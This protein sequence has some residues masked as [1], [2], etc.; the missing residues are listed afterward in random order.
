[1]LIPAANE[2]LLTGFD[3]ESV[4]R[5]SEELLLGDLNYRSGNVDLYA[6]TSGRI[7]AWPFVLDKI[8]KSPF[9]GYG[10]EAMIRT[11]ISALLYETYM[12]TLP[13]PY[14]MYLQWLLD[15]GIIGFLPVIIFYLIIIKYSISLLRKKQNAYDAAIGG[16]CLLLVMA[17]LIAGMGSQTTYPRDGSVA[18]WCTI[19]LVLRMYVERKS[20]AFKEQSQ[21]DGDSFSFKSDTESTHV[22]QDCQAKVRMKLPAKTQT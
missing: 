14:N 8:G 2:G 12:E 18:M 22:F 11:D 3:E 4:D 20:S 10:K 19:F 21:S 17:M 6:V 16:I 15:N 7:S 5:P 1:M 13:N 9:S